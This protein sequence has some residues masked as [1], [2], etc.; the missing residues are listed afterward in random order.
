MKKTILTTV[1]AFFTIAFLVIGCSKSGT[2]TSPS[3][4][5]EVTL[6]AKIQRIKRTFK[7]TTTQGQTTLQQQQKQ[8][9]DL[10]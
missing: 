5:D 1:I 9:P 6:Q 4:T 8:Y 2:S 3:N 10:D 7:M